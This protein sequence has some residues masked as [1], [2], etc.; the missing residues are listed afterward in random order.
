MAG[1]LSKEDENSKL[2]QL[3]LRL[4]LSTVIHPVEY[5]KFL[6]QVSSLCKINR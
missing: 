5:A 6:M 1:K 3:G 2:S 4:V